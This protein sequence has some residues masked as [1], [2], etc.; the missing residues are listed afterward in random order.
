[1]SVDRMG[2]NEAITGPSKRHDHFAQSVGGLGAVPGNPDFPQSLD[3]TPW[4]ATFSVSTPARKAQHAQRLSG[5]TGTRYE[6]GHITGPFVM[7]EGKITGTEDF[8][9]GGPERAAPIAPSAA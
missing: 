1:M 3:G 7:G 9:F 8:R 4:A 5:V 6:Q 2:A